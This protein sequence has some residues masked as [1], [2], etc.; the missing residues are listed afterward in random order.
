MS[1]PDVV[2]MPPVAAEAHLPWDAPV[3][4][5]VAV[6]AEARA[7]YTVLAPLGTLIF[8]V[9]SFSRAAHC[10]SPQVGVRAS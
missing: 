1:R 10:C 2:P 7:R 6:F 3:T 8:G 9:T 5:A 4:D